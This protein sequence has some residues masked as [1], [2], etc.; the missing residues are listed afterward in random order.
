MTV[1]AFLASTGLAVTALLTS[2]LMR[3]AAFVALSALGV[4]IGMFAF[5]LFGDTGL[6]SA[7][8]EGDPR[9]LR[10]VVPLAFGLAFLGWIAADL[11][12]AR[13]AGDLT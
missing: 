13:K 11:F 7:L 5:W 9:A 6:I 4:A 12:A 1:L 2:P 10:A 3:Q 8:L